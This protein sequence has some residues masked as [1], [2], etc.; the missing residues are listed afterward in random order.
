MTTRT[1]A[2]TSDERS[3]DGRGRQKWGVLAFVLLLAA[4]PACSADEGTSD[5]DGATATDIAAVD[6]AVSDGGAV[7]SGSADIAQQDGAGADA[8]VSKDTGGGDA[9]ADV[10]DPDAITPDVVDPDVITPDAVDPDGAVPDATGPETCGDGI[11]EGLE[12]CD[13][14]N[15]TD[16]DG[17]SKACKIETGYTCTNTVDINTGTDGGGGQLPPGEVDVRWDWAPGPDW[18]KEGAAGDNKALDKTPTTAPTGL[19]WQ[20]AM[21]VQK[22]VGAWHTVD[23]SQAAQWINAEGWDQVK[24]ACADVNPCQGSRLYYYRVKFDVASAAAAKGMSL[25]GKLW[26]DNQITRIWINGKQVSHY[27]DPVPGSSHFTGNGID[28]AGWTGYFKAGENE[29]IV[30]LANFTSPACPNPQGLVVAVDLSKSSV[31]VKQTVCGDGKVEGKEACDD[32][33]TNTGDGCNLVCTVETGFKCTTTAGKSNCSEMC[34]ADKDC[35]AANVFWNDLTGLKNKGPKLDLSVNDATS[36][37]AFP[38]PMAIDGKSVAANVKASF[39]DT[40]GKKSTQSIRYFTP[41]STKNGSFTSTLQSLVFGWKGDMPYLDLLFSAPP[42]VSLRLDFGE[43]ATKHCDECVYVLG[44]AGTGPG[45]PTTIAST[46]AMSNFGEFDAF[47]SKSYPTLKDSKT[48]LGSATN[49]DG[50]RFVLLAKDAKSI[51]LAISGPKVD[52]HGYIVGVAR[53]RKRKCDKG[54]CVADV[55]FECGN[56]K[57]EPGEGCDDGNAKDADGCSV[58]CAVETG[59]TCTET[60]GKSACVADCKPTCGGKTC[61]ADGCGGTCGTCDDKNGCTADSCTAAGTCS[62]VSCATGSVSWNS[63]TPPPGGKATQAAPYTFQI[64][65]WSQNISMYRTGNSSLVKL[66]TAPATNNG[67]FNSTIIPNLKFAWQGTFPYIDILSEKYATGGPM[68]EGIVTFDFGK[69]A[70][71]RGPSWRYVLVVG[72]LAGPGDEGPTRV[73][74]DVPLAF[75][76]EHNAFATGQYSVFK[77]PSTLET[78]KSGKTE[79]LSFF[80]LPAGTTKVSCTIKSLGGT[81]PDQHGYAV[82][83]VDMNVSQCEGTGATAKCAANVCGDGLIMGAEACD[84]GNS[85][86]N[87]GCTKCK[88]DANFTCTGD[89][90]SVCKKNAVCGNAVLEGQEECD[91]LNTKDG[92]GCSKDCKIED[93]YECASSVDINTGSD[94]AGKQAQLGGDDI[95]W[96]VALGTSWPNTT[97]QGN[98]DAVKSTPATPPATLTWQPSKV[99]QKCVGSWHTV[100]ASKAAQWVTAEGWNATSKT[101]VDPK[102]CA[103]GQIYYYRVKFN[104]INA[105]TAA[106]TSLQG[107]LWADNVITKIWINNKEVTQFKSSFPNSSFTGNGI[108]FAGWKGYYKAGENELVVAVV[109]FSNAGCPNPEGLVLSVDLAKGSVCTKKCGAFGEGCCPT[110]GGASACAAPF[111]CDAASSSCKCSTGGAVCGGACCK[112]GEFCKEGKCADPSTEKCLEIFKPGATV[113]NAGCVASKNCPVSCKAEL[114][115]NAA[116]KSGRYL[117]QPDA[118]KPAFEVQCDMLI[119]G[120]GW[121]LVGF[122]PAGAPNPKNSTGIMAQMAKESASVD[123]TKLA[124][125]TAAGFIGPR[126]AFKTQYNDAR[127]TWCT[128]A[129][130]YRYQK[131]TAT[132]DL[133]ADAVANQPVTAAGAA[134]E[135]VPLK[136]FSSNDADL[137]KQLAN[138]N[139]AA[140]CRAYAGAK[141]PGD[142]S[143][144]VKQK[145]ETSNVCG[146]NSK[147]WQGTGSYYGGKGGGG[148]NDGCSSWGGGWSGTAGNGVAKGSV[149]VNTTYFWVR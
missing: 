49:T 108:D 26:A 1:Y 129:T 18:M 72:G 98:L 41:P 145:G 3:A 139:D 79:G 91:D 4:Q 27:A 57:I 89:L 93:G 66:Y 109:N 137:N 64:N 33:N 70:K 81:M 121:T 75:I 51:D 38:I 63:L 34:A 120:G 74:C 86:D 32:G 117:V 140:F 53:I 146:C 103:N 36:T 102:V 87:D 80:T 56:G 13:D 60:A 28:F 71:T 141:V 148:N 39:I 44:V 65:G 21:S 135:M 127:L 134:G 136:N 115:S 22:C 46:V 78:G 47:A 35:A 14:K 17:C 128:A 7:D 123:T 2:A 58:K 110:T 20:P 52:P 99:V 45:G 82:G 122:E 119:D 84:D 48:I 9:A 143:W 95:R 144:G 16:G 67:S 37:F 112:A 107:K 12:E 19:A 23:A 88:V 130:A 90:K 83:M 114:D 100:D 77:A 142:T 126:F 97:Q 105:A 118:I 8:T 116:A 96:H 10:V 73:S 54:V 62:N 50:Y 104:L 132:A 111:A 149:N 6:S 55:A 25:Q 131:F 92:D 101:C 76:G 147:G 29:M 133:F 59:F 42:A 113:L 138:P 15:G 43:P 40:T 69:A 106:A 94:G 61:G 11:L 85:A 24:N 125:A 30:A 68:V 5:K 124:Q 31:C